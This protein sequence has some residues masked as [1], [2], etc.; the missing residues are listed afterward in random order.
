MA[1]AIQRQLP[2]R[3]GIVDPFKPYTHFLAKLYS[4]GISDAL[5]IVQIDWIMW[6][7]TWWQ[8]SSEH[9]VVLSLS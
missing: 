2:A 7:F 3:Q 5:E 4:S 1:V 9:I 6:H 8:M